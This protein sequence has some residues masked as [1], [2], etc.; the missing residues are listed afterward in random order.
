MEAAPPPLANARHT[1][2]KY[3]LLFSF[4]LPAG[5]HGARPTLLLKGKQNFFVVFCSDRAGGGTGL[6][7]L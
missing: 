3:S 6:Y 2:E 1:T 5:R 7:F 4:C